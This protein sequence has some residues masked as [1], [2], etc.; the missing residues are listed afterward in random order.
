MLTTLLNHTGRWATS[1]SELEVMCHCRMSL[2]N[3]GNRL[4]GSTH[5][6]PAKNKCRCMGR[7]H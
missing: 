2:A 5:C 3:W 4:A 7:R 6:E 1:R